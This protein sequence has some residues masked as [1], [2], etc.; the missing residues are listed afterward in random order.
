MKTRLQRGGT[1][2]WDDT[3]NHSRIKYTVNNRKINQNM[4]RKL[5]IDSWLQECGDRKHP[6]T[7]CGPWMMDLAKSASYCKRRRPSLRR[8]E[9]PNHDS[10]WTGCRPLTMNKRE[11][12]LPAAR[13]RVKA[14]LVVRA[15]LG[16]SAIAIFVGRLEAIYLSSPPN[17]SLSLRSAIS[18]S[19]GLLD[20]L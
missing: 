1:G 19:S 10:N 12:A 2:F 15:F 5:I 3:R 16:D 9:E 11:S 13:R 7:S 17:R 6:L 20:M 4:Q 8:A 14:L 18:Y